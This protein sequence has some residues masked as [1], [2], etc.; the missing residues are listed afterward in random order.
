MTG[1]REPA[2]VPLVPV[3]FVVLWSSGFVACK[4][5]L[6]DSGPFTLLFLRFLPAIAVS[7]VKGV[8]H[9][10]MQSEKGGH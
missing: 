4:A 10:Q 6:I 9:Q 2:W 5:A 1:A 7:E 8:L 3:V